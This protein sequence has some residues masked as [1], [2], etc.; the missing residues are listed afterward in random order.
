MCR[1][2]QQCWTNQSVLAELQFSF[3]FFW[4]WYQQYNNN[5]N[6]NDIIINNNN[7]I[8]LV[9]YSLKQTSL[10]YCFDVIFLF[11][12]KET[13]T[14]SD[15]DSS[16]AWFFTLKACKTNFYCLFTS[17]FFVFF[18]S[19]CWLIV[20]FDLAVLWLLF[21]FPYWWFCLCHCGGCIVSGLV[22]SGWLSYSVI[23]EFGGF[24]LAV[25]CWSCF[26]HG[27]QL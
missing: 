22:W 9:W 23:F 25:N 4:R 12:H 24:I 18:S 3:L 20:V 1:Q 2:Y 15:F 10:D 14:V 17:I 26:V 8:K 7:T 6:N 27:L 16:C 19:S 11:E 13:T 5:N 21:W